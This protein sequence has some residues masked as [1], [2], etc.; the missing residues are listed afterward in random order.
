MSFA[1]L[2]N[3]ALVV[4]IHAGFAAFVLLLTAGIFSM[5]KG[6]PLHRSMGW[7]WVISM[8]VIAI[9]SFWINEMRWIGPFGPIHLLSAF[10]L[11]SLVTGVRAARSGR[12]IEHKRTMKNLALYGLLVAGA[13]T[14]LPGRLMHDVFLGG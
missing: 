11:Y 7:I 6:S 9:S 3:A 10:V 2:T 13:F 1:P 14:F 4:Q 12:V 8:A 5:P